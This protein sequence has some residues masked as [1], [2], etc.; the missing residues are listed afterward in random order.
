MPEL[1]AAPSIN[2]TRTQSLLVLIDRLAALDLTPLLVYRIDSTVPSALSFLAW[3]FDILSP[4]W[5]LI[6]PF[7]L[8]VDALTNIDLLIDVDNLV[9]TGGLPTELVLSEAAQRALLKN[10]IALHRFRGTPWAIRRALDSLGWP[11]VTLL[12]GQTS[13]G[14]TTYPSNQGWAAFRV[15]IMLTAADSIGVVDSAT[16]VAAVNFFK[17]A[18]SWLD[19]LW[20]AVPAISDVAPTPSDKLTLSGIAKYQLDSAPAPTDHPLAYSI[21]LARFT[22]AYGPIVPA[23]DA[24]YRHSGITYGVNQPEVADSALVINGAAV[25]HGG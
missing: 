10:S 14:G 5:Q 15:V 12:E 7:A 23:Y 8:G 19:S 2:D 22:D 16:A 4:L 20:F 21:A 24:H 17:P 11:T 1:S 18:R 6:A 9:E 25:L 13:W 3:Q